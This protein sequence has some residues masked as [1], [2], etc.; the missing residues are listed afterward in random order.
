MHKNSIPDAVMKGI[1]QIYKDLANT[2]LL[3]KCQ[4]C[5]TQNSNES[6]SFVIWTRIPKNAFVGFET[7]QLRELDAIITFNTG[8]LSKVN[9]LENICGEVGS[10]NVIGLISINKMRIKEANRAV[11][12]MAKKAC[13]LYTSRCV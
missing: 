10:Y 12:E 1:K 8:P 5:R 4:H 13:L 3:K 6:L 7:L 11:E 9:F 2:N